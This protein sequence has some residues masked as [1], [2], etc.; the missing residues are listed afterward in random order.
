VIDSTNLDHAEL[1]GRRVER[2]VF[3]Q[4]RFTMPFRVAENRRG[5]G[6]EF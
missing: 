4:F 5:S 6:D 2:V 1:R 3:G